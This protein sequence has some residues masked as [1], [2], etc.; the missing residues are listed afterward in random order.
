MWEAGAAVKHEY[1]DFD[2]VS[3]A[4]NS[5]DE[6]LETLLVP[7][8]VTPAQWAT[9]N[10]AGNNQLSP[11]RRLAVAVFEQA[12]RDYVS[13]PRMRRE[14]RQWMNA[15]SGVYDP[16]CFEIAAEALGY[17]PSN[18]RMLA[19]KFMGTID[20]REKRGKVR[21]QWALTRTSQS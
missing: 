6:L 1:P 3:P 2:G 8:V 12:L 21:N 18:L 13:V 20:G 11:G 10:G 7:Y 4:V 19:E 9:T 14:I 17:A 16:F 15:A 5:A